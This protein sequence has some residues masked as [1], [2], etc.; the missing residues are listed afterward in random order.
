MASL[1]QQQKVAQLKFLNSQLAAQQRGVPGFATPQGST[2]TP[3]QAAS[4]G[5]PVG[6]AAQFAPGQ[7]PTQV[8]PGANVG[9]TPPI[10]QALNRQQKLAQ[11][12]Q[13]IQ[14]ALQK[15]APGKGKAVATLVGGV[16]NTPQQQQ[17]LTTSQ[18]A[19]IIAREAQKVFRTATRNGSDFLGGLSTPGTVWMPVLVLLVLLFFIVPVAGAD[20]KLHTRWG[21]L[22]LVLV[23]Q[24]HVQGEVL[25]KPT[26]A[27]AATTSGNVP[28]PFGSQFIPPPG[29]PP[30]TNKLPNGQC[31]PGYSPNPDKRN[32]N[33]PDCVYGP[34]TGPSPQGSGGIPQ[35]II[36]Q[37]L[38]TGNATLGLEDYL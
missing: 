21:W 7:Q 29:T 12:P 25:T 22:W 10:A 9:A 17:Q 35:N 38:Y 37:P 8:V 1:K 11:I 36:A 26:P 13:N 16:A 4:A 15:P 14:Q 24:A 23:G 27:S 32:P 30:T 18:Q 5:A 3:A 34:P 6:M 31:P 19:R 20:G 28:P 2:L 33:A